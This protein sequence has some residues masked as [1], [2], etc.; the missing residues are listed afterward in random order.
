MIARAASTCA[1]AL[2]IGACSAPPAIP[3]QAPRPTSAPAAP[4]APV[5]PPAPAPA[6]VASAA[7]TV[8]APPAPA[9][10]PTVKLGVFTQVLAGRF[11][12]IAV[13]ERRVA[14]LGDEPVML[15]GGRWSPRPLPARLRPRN[16]E[17]DEARI[18]FGRDD[19]PR[20]LGTRLGPDGEAP[21][22][23]RFRDG[24]WRE[25]HKEIGRLREAPLRG[26]FGVLGHADPEVVCKVG[27]ICLIK[28]RTG[29][30]NLPAGPARER[31]ELSGGVAWALREG[32]VARL[33]GDATWTVMKP[34]GSA[35]AIG[36]VWSAGDEVWVS[37]PG[38][39]R[40]HH[41][42]AGAWTD[43]PAPFA[44]PRG[45]WGPSRADVWLA[46]G[47]GLAHYDGARWSRVEGPRGA[48]AEVAGRGAEVWAAGDAGV[49]MRAAP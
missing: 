38:S 19:L 27:D 32:A 28:R 15:E 33:D 34:P 36:G 49:W 2:V 44:D 42:H 21:I 35:G 26:L 3:P 30:K 17:R 46:G 8:A 11:A 12:S 5:G 39:A 47:G 14:A 48:V 4:S 23:L 16:G 9:A 41:F 6:P 20:L 18:F 7:A 43:E 24:A 37:E 31:I 40:L 13:G 45:F 1:I 22:Y 10:W 29:W 25:E